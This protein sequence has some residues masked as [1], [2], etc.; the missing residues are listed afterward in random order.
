MTDAVTEARARAQAAL[1][2]WREARRNVNDPASIPDRLDEI[3]T[4]AERTIAVISQDIVTEVEAI[5]VEL[6]ALRFPV[7]PDDALSA[8]ETATLSLDGA[9]GRVARAASRVGFAGAEDDLALPPGVRVPVQEIADRLEAFVAAIEDIKPVLEKIG[10]A[11]AADPGSNA[12]QD[13]MVQN[14]IDKASVKIEI[15]GVKTGKVSLIDVSGIAGLARQLTNLLKSFVAMIDEAAGRVSRWLAR[16]APAWIDMAI[17]PVAEGTSHLVGRA[18]AWIRRSEKIAASAHEN[19]TKSDVPAALVFDL[20]EVERMISRGEVPPADVVPFV[21]SFVAYGFDAKATMVLGHMTGLRKLALDTSVG[22]LSP[23]ANLTALQSLNLSGSQ[24]SDLS[25]LAGL[26]A[27]QFLSIAYTRVADLSPLAGLTVLQS[28]AVR[29]SPVNDLSPLA[30]LTAL[31]SLNLS[32]AQVSDLAPLANLTAFRSL[33]LSKT[34]VSDLSPLNGLTALQSLNLSG[35][36]V[37]DLSPLNGLTAL[38]SLNLSGTQ[39]SNL[40][41]LAGLAALQSLDLQRTQVSDLAPLAGFVAL[42][43][44]DLQR[45]QVS[46]LAPLAGLVALHSLDLQRTQVSDL[47]PLAGLVALHSLDLQNTQVSNLAPL[48]SLNALPSLDLTGTKVSDLSPLRNLPNLQK[49]SI[50]Q[51]NASVLMATL[52]VPGDWADKYVYHIKRD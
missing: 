14:F 43:S 47:A 20:L 51:G 32:G 52:G 11:Q 5:V 19:I 39:V 26:T 21:T 17:A 8:L 25:P 49:I 34:Q 4:V 3:V 22:D 38:Q 2:R 44:L 13:A 50:Y 28:L 36:Q 16:E 46:D 45:T 1:D 37:S 15:I 10:T 29:G 30:G 33:D 7:D 31:Q 23:L 35:T 24:V 12:K 18:A 9:L 42:H 41:P 6:A 48:A 40:S 27:L